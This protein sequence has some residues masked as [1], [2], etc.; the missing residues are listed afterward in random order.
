MAFLCV[1]SFLT[2]YDRNCI[3][4]ISGIIQADLRL[5]NLQMGAVFSAFWLAYALFEIPSGFL[6]D[7]YGARGTLA[8]IVLAWSLF[9]ALSGSATGFVSL[10][11]FRFLFGV[12][13]AG[14]YPNMARIQSAW[15]T[16]GSRARA[17]GLLW[18]TARWGAAFAPFIFGWL[19]Q[20][21]S[22]DAFHRAFAN[23]GLERSAPWRL[24]FYASGLLGVI[25]VAVFWLWFR[26]NPADKR[27]VNEAEL[28][29]IRAGAPTTTT[30]ASDAPIP[31]IFA[32]LFTSPSLWALAILYT[33]VSFGWSFFVSWMPT[34]FRDV[35]HVSLVNSRWM[36][37]LPLFFGGISCLL[38][39]VL[40][41]LVIKRTGNKRFGRAVFPVIGYTLAA[42]AMLGVRLTHTPWQA[43]I[44]FCIAATALD[45][46]QGANWASI[47]DIG[48]RYAG[49][50]TG[51]VNMIGNIGGNALQPILG[52]WIFT[53]LGWNA[54]FF[55]Y[56]ATSLAAASMWLFINPDRRFYPESQPRARGF[57]VVQDRG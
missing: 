20:F 12:G 13:E 5:S 32:S 34:F 30:N 51:F 27:S 54:L 16:P 25:W 31:N 9:T 43:T 3:S 37:A 41:D 52:A 50:A 40:S 22:G 49:S 6:G 45:L 33:C 1:L 35:Q 18:L 4:T 46:G 55:T 17:G 21:F 47:V 57:E 38:G 24:S 23:T 28:E 14:A 11:T 26:D 56:A 53:Q 10:L 29:L 8:R 36:T 44:L 15:L 2:Y 19:M 7:R 48:G 42:A 39:G